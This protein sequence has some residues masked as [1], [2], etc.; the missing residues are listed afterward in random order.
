MPGV[1]TGQAAKR[2]F[3]SDSAMGSV[4]KELEALP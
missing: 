4:R 2:A 1:G 3:V